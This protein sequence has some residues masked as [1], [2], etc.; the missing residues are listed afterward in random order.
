[1]CNHLRTKPLVIVLISTVPF[2]KKILTYVCFVHIN[3]IL[4]F[5]W[6]LTWCYDE[7]ISKKYIFGPILNISHLVPYPR[8]ISGLISSPGPCFWAEA[9]TC[10]HQ[11]V[12]REQGHMT[13]V[14]QNI[15]YCTRLMKQV[16]W[17]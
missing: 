1:M 11:S 8:S 16:P 4:P 2:K 7:H 14:H 9:I 13:P 17:Q 10:V 6:I 3:N 15:L 5:Y 12:A